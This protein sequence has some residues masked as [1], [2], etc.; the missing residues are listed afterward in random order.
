[1]ARQG[2]YKGY[3]SFE[4]ENT[5][6]FRINDIEL[7]K[8]DLMN[9]IF[10][11]RGERLMM[12]TFGTIIPDLAFEPL[13]EVTLE[14]LQNDLELVFDYDPRVA[15]IDLIITPS[16][17]TNTVNVSVLLRYIELDQTDVLDFNIT[18]GEET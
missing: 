4:F 11:R 7:V 12:P 8:L 10:T 13:D 16:Y 2:L 3:S 6:S 1:M 5:G 15:L 9:H 17:D 14:I 18:V